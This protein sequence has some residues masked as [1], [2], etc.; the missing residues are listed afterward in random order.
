MKECFKVL[1]AC[2]KAGGR[3]LVHCSQGVNRSPSVVVAWLMCSKRTRWSLKDA[4]THVKARRDCVSPHYLYFE[5][6]QKIECKEHRLLKPSI[7]EE[8]SGIFVPPGVADERALAASAG[9]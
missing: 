1:E 3:C 4:W 8:E 9:Q 2:Q 5:K 7:S 6:L